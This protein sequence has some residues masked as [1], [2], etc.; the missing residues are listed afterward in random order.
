MLYSW[1]RNYNI[2]VIYSGFSLI[3]QNA[4]LCRAGKKIEIQLPNGPVHF[5][6]QLRDI[7]VVRCMTK[8]TIYTVSNVYGWFTCTKK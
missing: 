5:S 4:F 6:G 1:A 2:F 8:L 3:R 7:S